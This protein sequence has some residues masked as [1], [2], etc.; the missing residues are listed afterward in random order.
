MT[1]QEETLILVVAAQEETTESRTTLRIM[2]RTVRHRIGLEI[3]TDERH[4]PPE[5]A[6]N[7]LKALV[8]FSTLASDFSA[9][10]IPTMTARITTSPTELTAKDTL[11]MR[12]R[13]RDSKSACSSTLCVENVI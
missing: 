6:I 1:S 9:L 3:R 8:L 13:A 11:E 5:N 4:T 7:I 10:S 2:E 12:F